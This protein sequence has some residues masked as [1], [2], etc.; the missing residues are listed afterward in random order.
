MAPRSIKGDTQ[1]TAPACQTDSEQHCHCVPLRMQQMVPCQSKTASQSTSA[2]A[3]VKEDC[4][5]HGS[6]RTADVR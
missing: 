3:E 5:L 2:A 6:P 4:A 1:P